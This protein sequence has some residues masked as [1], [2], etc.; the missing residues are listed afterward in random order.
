MKNTDR[1]RGIPVA[2]L[3][4]VALLVGGCA[5]LEQRSGMEPES[6]R[7][8]K[9][10]QDDDFWAWR[11]AY[12]TGVFDP[13]WL[14]ESTEQVR[15]IPAG[16]PAGESD[17]SRSAQSPLYLDRSRF[18]PLGPLP[19]NPGNAAASG[20]ANVIVVDPLDP[21]IA[22]MGSDG[23]GVWKT[24]N[25]CSAA[26]TWEV[27][28][29]FPEVASMAIS[30]I[31]IDPSN[32]DVIYAGTGD[33]RFGGF[34]FGSAGV[35]KS[36]D[37]GESWRVLGADTFGMIYQSMVG[38]Y[39]QYQSVGKVV[40]DPNDSNNVV[41][42]AKTGLYFSNDA[43]EHWTGPCY[44]NPYATGA[45]PQRQDI[46]GLLALNRSGTTVLYAV[47]GTRGI[48]TP[49]QADLGQTGAN[50]VYRAAMPASGCPAV[51][52]WTLLND[53]WPAGTGNGVG[54]ATD[55]GRI[56]IV[57]APTDN[58]ILYAMAASQAGRNV[59][60]VFRSN[61]GGDTW[62][63]T[64]NTAAVRAA[65]PPGVSGGSC[66]SAAGGGSQMWYDA[67]LT[68]DPTNADVVYL[69]G[70]DLYR[71]TDG[72]Q[73]F[74][75][76]T[77]G[78]SSGFNVHVD[79]HARAFVG[80]DPAKM[81]VGSDGG[82][83]YSANVNA[84]TVMPTF[85]PLND[86][87][88]TIE[89]YSG[90]ITANFATSNNPGI[91]G[92][93]QDNGSNTAQW[94]N[95]YPGVTGWVTRNGGDG[96]F[97]RIEPVLGKR[98]YYA[99]QNGALRV[100]PNGP[101]GS[102]SSAA[103]PSN[104]GGDRLSFVM[105]Y[106]IYKYGDVNVP[107]SGCDATNG[108]PRLIAGTMR[109]WET[110]TGASPASSWQ[111]KT[112]DLTKGTLAIGSDNRSY[113][114]QL[115]YSVTDPKIAIVGTNDGNVQ[116]VFG[117]GTAGVAATPVDVTGGNLVLPNRPIMDVATDPV[118]P[119]IG[120]ATV[121]GFDQNTPAAPGHVFKVTCSANC[122][123]FAWE[124]KTGNLPNIPANTVIANPHLPNQVFV[125]TDWGLFYTDDVTAVTPQ[126]KRFEGLPHAMIWDLAIDR[127]FT[128]LAVFTRSRGAWAWPLPKYP[129][130]DVI[131]Q[132]QFE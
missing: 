112:P 103:A 69:S 126:W 31:T 79:H 4:V 77:C 122:A 39:P 119:L 93:A 37:R 110:L 132:N 99:S 120:Y 88:N 6:E 64:A 22:Y 80:N 8:G 12:P 70:V 76:L 75:D 13:M 121:G 14:V 9:Q 19:L 102:Q 123:T 36:T 65:R 20:R 33:L 67:G 108:C 94:S 95:E 130:S 17:Y 72:G 68:V 83:F 29:D 115:A 85:I 1:M 10:P 48:P 42:G 117:L 84:A 5:G 54:G 82:V 92:G 104:W 46:T 91:S 49:T 113:I 35:L 44:T 41:A 57:A 81:L 45:D 3:S 107:E 53:N 27:K 30:D 11:V 26:T 101:G 129:L 127:G 71:S 87:I 2:A 131:F 43:G 55:V 116:Y 100:A 118:N 52:N 106:E 32:R 111:A 60:G 38:N 125:G 63:Q 105:P 50:G 23:G 128:T 97:T 86:T 34:S 16:V 58:R 47:V 114:N 28:T 24:T 18:T 109:V 89:F 7:G 62:T 61:D 59:L 15:R 51:A 96:I 124:N 21:Q 98:W 78:Y 90:D 66:S 40:V 73:N 56:E 25:C 74:Y